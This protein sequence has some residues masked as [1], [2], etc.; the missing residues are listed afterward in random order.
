MSSP[1][2]H[3]VGQIQHVLDVLPRHDEAVDDYL[4]NKLPLLPLYEVHRIPPLP[5]GSTPERDD[6][7]TPPSSEPS[8]SPPRAPMAKSDQRREASDS[9]VN[10]EDLQAT[11][12]PRGSTRTTRPL[13][14]VLRGKCARDRKKRI[15]LDD[16]V[17]RM[18]ALEERD[19]EYKER[20]RRLQPFEDLGMML[21]RAEAYKRLSSATW[22]WILAQPQTP[23]VK[24]EQGPARQWHLYLNALDAVPRGGDS[25]RG[26]KKQAVETR[27]LDGSNPLSKLYQH[28]VKALPDE[29]KLLRQLQ[30]EY[31]AEGKE[32][33]EKAHPQPRTAHFHGDVRLAVEKLKLVHYDA[34]SFMD[35]LAA[36]LNRP[37]IWDEHQKAATR[38]FKLDPPPPARP[39]AS[40]PPLR[41]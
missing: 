2:W 22:Q 35:H 31:L 29:V 36:I 10:E 17:N 16:L 18:Q 28:I 33:N 39:A 4:R 19:K 15:A 7:L 27:R 30:T 23:K 9:S 21:Q 25:S 37:I 3:P 13:H 26:R 12:A 20:F 38:P 14:F 32:R 8:S 6:L 11:R 34:D 24:L 41:V 40:P 5:D 1:P